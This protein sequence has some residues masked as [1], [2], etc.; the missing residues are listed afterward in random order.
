MHLSPKI[1]LVKNRCNCFMGFVFLLGG[2]DHY[3][4]GKRRSN[5]KEKLL[6]CRLEP[7]KKQNIIQL[8]PPHLAR[9]CWRNN[10]QYFHIVPALFGSL[11]DSMRFKQIITLGTFII[12]KVF[13]SVPTSLQMRDHWFILVILV[14]P[15]SETII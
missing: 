8:L 13:C 1:K 6:F 11:S 3:S 5:S 2:L 4:N 7:Q 9:I 10:S 12:L 14:Q 15:D